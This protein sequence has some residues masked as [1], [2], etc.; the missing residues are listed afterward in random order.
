MGAYA[1][2]GPRQLVIG[3]VVVVLLFLLFSAAIAG[4]PILIAGEDSWESLLGQAVASVVWEASM[5]YVV[6]RIVRSRRA[7]WREL[8]FRR[9]EG[10]VTPHDHPFWGVVA[11]VLIAYVASLIAVSG[12]MLVINTLGLDELLPEP[13]IPEALYD[14]AWLVAVFGVAVVAIAPF[15]EEVFF[16]GFLYGGLRRSWRVPLAALVSGVVFSSAHG[17]PGLIVPFTL[18]GAILAL[19]Y[20]RTGTIFGSMGVHFLFNLGSFAALVFFPELRD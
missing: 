2:W 12:Y 11:V 1:T 17:D 5:I 4:P 16:R 14:H 6:Y 9:P 7:G 3:V 15:A 19:T 18:V 20:E 8:G 10:A 13:Q